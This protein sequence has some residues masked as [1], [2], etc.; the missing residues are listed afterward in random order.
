MQHF[1]WK[2]EN[3][4]VILFHDDKDN[5]FAN[6]CTLANDKSSSANLKQL[7]TFKLTS[8]ELNCSL[9]KFGFRISLPM[10]FKKLSFQ[11]DA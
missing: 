7:Q 5:I 9:F 10:T 11:V 2:D 6:V 4:P 3:L 1:R 8:Q